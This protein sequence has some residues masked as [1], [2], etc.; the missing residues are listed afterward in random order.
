ML[1]IKIASA[2]AFEYISALFSASSSPFPKIK[3]S[4]LA[5]SISLFDEHDFF[6]ISI[7]FEKIFIFSCSC[8]IFVP[9]KEFVQKNTD[10]D[11]DE[12]ILYYFRV[13][14][15]PIC[16]NKSDP[17]I[18]ELKDF[19]EK[20]PP[21]NIP[22]TFITINPEKDE[23][24][25]EGFEEKFNINVDGYPSIFLVK[26]DKIVEYNANPTLDTLKDFIN[27]AL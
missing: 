4:I 8:L 2:P 7:L 1:C 22:L 17:V 12:A 21:P 10:A 25:A 16:K 15:C 11:V 20:N 14:W 23:G 5:I 18:K 24:A 26:G 13:D 9:N 27:A 19:Y 6:P 3:L